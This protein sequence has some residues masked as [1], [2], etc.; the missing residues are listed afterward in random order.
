MWRLR[1][2]GMSCKRGCTLGGFFV[3]FRAREAR[4][5]DCNAVD[6]RLMKQ[7]LE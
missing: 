6:Y 2:A 1:L 5:A 7:A 4:I 3:I